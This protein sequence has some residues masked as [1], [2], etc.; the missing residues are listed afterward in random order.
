MCVREQTPPSAVPNQDNT[1]S[2]GYTTKSLRSERAAV[3]HATPLQTSPP[4]ASS[5][6][7][8]EVDGAC[9]GAAL[10]REAQPPH[11]RADVH[12]GTT[13]GDRLS[14]GFLAPSWTTARSKACC[15]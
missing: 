15:N 4:T 1:R 10:E 14:L 9:G 12:L 13:R 3:P 2:P 8:A 5:A 11:E 6:V 7:I